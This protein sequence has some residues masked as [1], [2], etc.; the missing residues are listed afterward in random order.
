[1]TSEQ[2]SS[3][4]TLIS[5]STTGTNNT[6]PYT[7]TEASPGSVKMRLQATTQYH[8]QLFSGQQQLQKRQLQLQQQ[9]KRDQE[10]HCLS[11]MMPAKPEHSFDQ[12]HSDPLTFVPPNLYRTSLRLIAETNIHAWWACLVDILS[13][14]SFHAARVFLSVPQDAS[15]PWIGPWGLRAVWCKSSRGQHGNSKT[16]SNDGADYFTSSQ[17]INNCDGRIHYFERLQAFESEP[18]PLINNAGIQRVIR[19]NAIVVLSREYRQR[20]KQAVVARHL[21]KDH[22]H[23]QFPP[24]DSRDVFKRAIVDQREK[25]A[26]ASLCH[27]TLVSTPCLHR[28]EESNG[29]ELFGEAEILADSQHITDCSFE[30]SE[31]QEDSELDSSMMYDYDEYEQQQPSPWSQSPAPSPAMMDPDTNPFF[32]SEPVID[33]EA[34]NP[35]SPESYQSSSIPFPLPPSNVHSVIHIPLTH[36]SGNSENATD[37]NSF[38]TQYHPKNQTAPIAVLSFLSSVVP[39]PAALI[40]SLFSLAPFIATSFL[41]ASEHAQMEKH[42]AHCGYVKR[43]PCS[44]RPSYNRRSKST[45]TEQAYGRSNAIGPTSD[46]DTTSPYAAS[47][48][49]QQHHKPV[50]V[51]G[52]PSFTSNSSDTVTKEDQGGSDGSSITSSVEPPLSPVAEYPRL[53]TCAQ[54]IV[55]SSAEV[56]QNDKRGK[57]TYLQTGNIEVDLESRSRS[58]F[59]SS[60][61]INLPSPM[62][63]LGESK[64]ASRSINV[65][66]APSVRPAGS[67]D[68]IA[69][70]A[71]GRRLNRAAGNTRRRRRKYKVHRRIYHSGF[72]H[73]KV[74]SSS[75]EDDLNSVTGH[76]PGKSNLDRLFLTPKPSLLRLVIDGIPIHVL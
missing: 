35:A 69:N 56:I 24:D 41:N 74:V 75:G 9:Q 15:D 76:I 22:F 12:H 66:N 59:C 33:D 38:E 32:Q 19:R 65:V 58:S 5:D 13:Q 60:E 25:S 6:S 14:S 17:K 28:L 52:L 72:G 37:G 54:S 57:E 8:A 73:V 27:T 34:F 39:Y 71:T 64:P 49:D 26:P 70:N 11:G 4:P 62:T 55:D 46:S 68:L 21:L 50:S 63:I 20:S 36:G 31:R 53:T 48:Q 44:R 7:T 10:N 1:M 2:S 43:R 51:S 42:Y 45:T 16:E 40:S 23:H 47:P 67:A 30:T 3:L 29:K 61:A 18:E